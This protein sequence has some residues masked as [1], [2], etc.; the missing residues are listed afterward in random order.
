MIDE[1]ILQLLKQIKELAVGE[2]FKESLSASDIE[3]LLP[4]LKRHGFEHLLFDILQKNEIE[5][6]K[7]FGIAQQK[8]KKTVF[9]SILQQQAQENMTNALKKANIPYILLKGA[10]IKN[11]YGEAWMRISDDIDILVRSED[12]EKAE[13]VAK[14]A[15]FAFNSRSTHDVSFV[16]A[17]KIK[18][19]LHYD[20]IEDSCAKDANKVLLKVWD[21]AIRVSENE[22]RLTDEMT[23]FYHIAHLA[24]HF[25]LGGCGVRAI[26]DTFLL[27]NISFDKEKREELLREG[28]LKVFSKKVEALS[29]IWFSED[30]NEDADV[31]TMA[32]YIVRGGSFGS[33][34]NFAQANE[35]K[36]KQTLLRLFF[37]KKRDMEKLFPPVKKYALLLPVF[38]LV[39]ILKKIFKGNNS[40]SIKKIKSL[41][42]KREQTKSATEFFKA[43]GL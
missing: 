41:K 39:R 27:N 10:V 40:H 25:E 28:G 36:E 8:K 18:I 13:Q 34:S 31:D 11:L 35:E 24:K 22:Y 20:L 17:N 37:P 6:N 42:S 9:K 14:G 26:L 4:F 29:R 33:F 3:S 38:W 2:N 21:S 12:I 1:K 32:D 15:G 16:D 5:E 19:E 30:K 43:I 7:L 23:Y